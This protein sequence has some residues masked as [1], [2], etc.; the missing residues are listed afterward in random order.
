MVEEAK[1]CEVKAY[2]C[3]ANEDCSWAVFVP[4]YNRKEPNILKMLENDPIL[5][6]NLCVRS[7]EDDKGFYDELKKNPRIGILRCGYNLYDSGGTRIAIMEYCWI[8]GIKYAVMFDDPISNV[9]DTMDKEKLIST[10]IAECVERL[11][12]D[13]MS[14][15][16]ILFQFH[17]AERKYTNVSLDSKYFVGMPL[18]AFI[19]NTDLAFETGLQFG[20]RNEVGFEDEAFFIDSVKEGLITCSD[21]RYLVE[22]GLPNVPKAGGSHANM[23]AETL[24]QKY[25]RLQ[26]VFLKHIGPTYGVYLTK[27]YRKSIGGLC[28]YGLFD[29]A[30]FKDVLVDNRELNKDIIESK[31]QIVGAE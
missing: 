15:N 24:E 20:T 14:D 18:Q 7:D 6:I 16:C 11:E 13:P 30:F 10:C 27:A 8:A 19:V 26:Q 9:H 29:Y 3:T 2:A 31:F 28:S 12:T 25:D 5:H 21:T 4:T 1:D 23:G 22:G 17:R